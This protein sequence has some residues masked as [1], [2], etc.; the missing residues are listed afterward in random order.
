M[1]SSIASLPRILPVLAA[2]A[3]GLLVQPVVAQ[4]GSSNR[5]SEPA[6]LFG[7]TIAITEVEIPVQVL[8]RGEPLRG[9]TAEDFQVFDAGEPAEV[10][11]FRTID[12]TVDTLAIEQR[13]VPT[14]AAVGTG[15]GRHILFLFDF[16]F[17][18]GHQIERALH[19]GRERLV[20]S[21]HPEDRIA[22]GYLSSHGA[23]ILLGFS[24]DR[25]EIG[26]AIDL[27]DAMAD[28][29]GA[30]AHRAF[31]RLAAAQYLAPATAAELD[32]DARTL[33]ARAPAPTRVSALGGR[34]GA[35]AAVAMLGGV[36]VSPGDG[37]G[38]GQGG[39]G[40]PA[41]D[42]A[43]PRQ[44]PVHDRIVEANPFALG[45]GVAAAEEAS[46][47]RAQTDQIAEVATLLRD[48][49]G[50]KHVLLLSRGFSSSIF[51]ETASPERPL[52]L[53]YLRRMHESL[54]RADWTLHTYDLAGIKDPFNPTP[55][56]ADTLFYMAN[57]TGGQLFANY[58]RLPDATERLLVKTSV[59][60]VL[61]IRPPDDLPANSRLRRLEVRL[62][63]KPWLARVHHR[64]GYYA[65]KPAAERS[66]LERKLDTIDLLLGEAEVDG[67]PVAVEAETGPAS[68]GLAPVA[69]LVTLPAE[70][71]RDD[72]GPT[73]QVQIQV[74][75][76]DPQGGVQDLW[77]RRVV[78]DRETVGAQL[79][80]A[81]LQVAGTL[82][83]PPGEYRLRS[84]VRHPASDRFTL[85]TTEL[86][87]ER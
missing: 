38:G 78:L 40:V 6:E 12:L 77:T 33:S 67:L 66:S 41:F 9:L 75:A 22:V 51:Q 56:N 79:A 83:L 68:G 76:V 29:R 72:S 45:A 86:V 44:D 21:L 42:G 46:R 10:V 69:L 14:P 36:D 74:Y 39:A 49:P 71:F 13:A 80:A 16:L 73:T 62:R 82:S 53:R 43:D 23:R 64:T 37:W 19:R 58:N 2:L 52:V 31:L 18:S 85:G 32:A 87:I 27:I 30:D 84:L 34:F 35:S 4:P 59:T 63:D 8:H 1:S 61:T 28:G 25:E 5:P 17:S 26:T 3:P 60:Y 15:G 24:D 70:V 57:E 47:V 55:G 65:P 81:G 50:P 48:V 11:A 20:G 54:R 7:E